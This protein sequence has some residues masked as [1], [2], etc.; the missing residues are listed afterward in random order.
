MSSAAATSAVATSSA[1][2]IRGAIE[3]AP[4]SPMA[5]AMDARFAIRRLIRAGARGF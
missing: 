2:D 5:A 1:A 4:I 3:Y